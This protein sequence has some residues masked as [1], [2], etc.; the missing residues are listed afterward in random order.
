MTPKGRCHGETP[1]S[2]LPMTLPLPSTHNAE[3]D[4]LTPAMAAERVGISASTLK[5][6]RLRGEGPR[7]LR[8]TARTI[9][10]RRTDLDTWLRDCQHDPRGSAND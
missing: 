9:R 10:Y 5:R 3:T 8:L 7:V 1:I 2:E 4:L 6:M